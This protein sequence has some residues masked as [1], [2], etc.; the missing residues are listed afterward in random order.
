MKITTKWTIAYA[1]IILFILLAPVV[2]VF[3]VLVEDISIGEWCGTYIPNRDWY[4]PMGCTCIGK[5]TVFNIERNIDDPIRGIDG[6]EFHDYKCVGIAL[7]M[8]YE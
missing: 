1:F 7:D 4:N 5:K 3:S 2:H 6:E 8:G